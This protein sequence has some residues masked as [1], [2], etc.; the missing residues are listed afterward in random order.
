MDEFLQNL[1][2]F[3]R[4]NKIPVILDDTRDYLVE[5]CKTLQ[6]KRILEI[7]MA[8]GYSASNLLKASPNANI[9]CLEASL[10][11]I[12][13]ARKNF[14]NQGLTERVNII[15][16]DCML[17]LPKLKGQKFDLIFLD[18]PKGKYLEMIDMILPLLDEEGVWVSDNV[19][20][21]GMV[22]DNQPIP[23][24]RFEATVHILRDFLDTLEQNKDLDTQVLHIGD[25]LSVVKFK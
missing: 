5:L 7:G 23:F 10:P 15:E 9:T 16:G 1:E 6:P 18:G 8:I 12:E 25:G 14:A 20:F 4:L 19:L 2:K 22:R 21:R 11:N 17:E 13:M 3:A 24:P